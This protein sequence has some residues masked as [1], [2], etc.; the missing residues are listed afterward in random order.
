MRNRKIIL[1][2]QSQHSECGLAV[3]VMILKYYGINISLFEIQDK[4][5]IP[6]G[7]TSFSDL[8]KILLDYGLNSRGVKVN[9]ISLLKQLN[10][11]IICYW[12]SDHFVIL[13]KVK[14]R[15]YYVVDPALGKIILT[16]EEFIK[17]FNNVVLIPES[18]FKGKCINNT[19]GIGILKLIFSKIKKNIYII[20]LLTILV[21][22]MSLFLAIIQKYIIDNY[23]Y[24]FRNSIFGVIFLLLLVGFLYYILQRGR[25][26][27][28]TNFQIYFERNILSDF[29]K[30]MVEFPLRFFMNRGTGDLLFR[31]NSLYLIQQILSQRILLAGVDLSFAIVYLIAMIALSPLLSLF[32]IIITVIMCCISFIYSLKYR[33]LVSKGIVNEVS[34]QEVFVEFFE[35]IDTIKSLSIERYFDS[36]WK[37]SFLKKQ[38]VDFEKGKLTANLNTLYASLQFIMPLFIIVIG[39]YYVNEG[40]FSIGTVISFVSLSG[41]F[42]SPISTVLDS[43]AQLLTVSSYS[44]KIVEIL[45]YSKQ[46]DSSITIDNKNSINKFISLTIKNMSFRYSLFEDMCLKNI[47]LTINSGDRIA[48][49]GPSGS[50]KSTL[51]KLISGLL[52]VSDGEILINNM[53]ISTFTREEISKF[54]AYSNQNSSVFNETI[55]NNILLAAKDNKISES[56]IYDI[57]ERLGI[58][59]IVK[60]NPL[61][62]DTII[63]NSGT[64][65]SGG[66]LQRIVLS[67]IIAL[68]SPVLI[69]DEPTSAL[70][71]LSED[72]IF[73]Y[74]LEKSESMVVV[75]HRL[76][77]LKKFDKIIVMNNGMICESGTHDELIAQNG[78]YKSLY[79]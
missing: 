14:N 19:Y 32:V 75:A 38:N 64:N 15:K 62:I 21:Q 51:L 60:A 34:T 9:D 4:Y 39:L 7:G 30:K 52:K 42:I 66:Q 31:I 77:T 8:K 25:I 5:G 29:M 74:L 46:N 13:E 73:K 23:I 3:V 18:E 56:E 67:R 24:F 40:D 63:T 22:G 12:N 48:I 27:A 47:N 53:N 58:N 43:Y 79:G 17:S 36:K 55:R 72:Y 20:L 2:E 28:F 37:K 26:F 69:L 16:E 41:A 54:I 45:E 78:L 11:P 50:G 35:N 59:E 57:C 61:G 44:N 49:V 65:I 10:T 71:N 6:R 68:N 33:E 70:D 76:H 1:V